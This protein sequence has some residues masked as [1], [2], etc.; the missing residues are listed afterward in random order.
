M[1]GR[2]AA[3][4]GYV[5]LR[6]ARALV[7]VWGVATLVFVLVRVVPGDPVETMLGDHASPEDRRALRQALHL[8]RPL[9]AQ[10]G[11][12]LMDIGDGSLGRSFRSRERTVSSILGEVLAPTAALAIASLLL[13]WML[14]VPLG[15]IAAVHHGTSVDRIATGASI[16]GLAIPNIWL[17]PLL[18]LVFSVKLRWL[19]LP[20]GDAHPIAAIVLP[21]ITLG[22]AMA[23]ILARQTRATLLEVLHQ[24]YI[25]AAR[26][27][28]LSEGIVVLKHGLRNALIPVAT[29]GAA[30]LGALLSGTIVTE[31]IFEREGL[32][33]VFLEAFFA[34][35][36]PVIQGA[37]LFFGVVYVSVNLAVDLFYAVA[38]PRVRL[39]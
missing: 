30:Q 28:G 14:A 34:R 26:A 8:D 2:L 3:V 4:I 21:V 15:T 11:A 7:T 22:T 18:L 17:G 33:T 24:Q 25:L 36:F 39:G 35:D 19:P 16:V 29:V 10:Y 5:A 13:A 23:A 6:C 20:G 37:V 9:A 38:D 1:G 31:R 12:F 27:R 32:G